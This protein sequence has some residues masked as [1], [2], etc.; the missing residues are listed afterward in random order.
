MMHC[1]LSD[2][3]LYR[4]TCGLL[5]VIDTTQSWQPSNRNYI[6]IN[7]R[8]SREPYPVSYTKETIKSKLIIMD[9]TN[10]VHYISCPLR[11]TSEL[12]YILEWVLIG[13]LVSKPGSYN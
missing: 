3:I 13:I 1:P 9:V 5:P 7:Y 2:N 10:M 11:F 12:T 6:Q 4:V 8:V